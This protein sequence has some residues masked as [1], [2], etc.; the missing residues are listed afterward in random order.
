MTEI[1]A[2][3][4][5]KL[6]ESFMMGKGFGKTKDCW[7]WKGVCVYL[8]YSKERWRRMREER[9]R[10]ADLGEDKEFPVLGAGNAWVIGAKDYL[11]GLIQHAE[12]LPGREI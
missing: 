9:R 12:L 2:S 11:V 8:W 3:K 6:A 1:E 4:T 5:A 10:T 7:M